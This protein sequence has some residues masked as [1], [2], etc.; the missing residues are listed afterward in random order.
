MPLFHE[1]VWAVACW[2][3]RAPRMTADRSILGAI[4]F[5]D[6]LGPVYGGVDRIKCEEMMVSLAIYN[7]SKII[8]SSTFSI[9]V[10]NSR[11]ILRMAMYSDP[12]LIPCNCPGI[13][14]GNMSRI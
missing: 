9:K 8:K 14:C 2:A 5:E 10:C 12:T 4:M 3:A 7:E 13:L 6:G 11:A 1:A